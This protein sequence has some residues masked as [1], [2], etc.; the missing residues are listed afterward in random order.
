MWRYHKQGSRGKMKSIPHGRF[1]KGHAFD[2][3]ASCPFRIPLQNSRKCIQQLFRS[4]DSTPK[5]SFQ[6]CQAVAPPVPVWV[7]LGGYSGLLRQ[8]HTTTVTLGQM[9]LW[10]IVCLVLR[11]LFVSVWPCSELATCSGC[12]SPSPQGNRERLQYSG[13][14]ECRLKQWQL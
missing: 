1:E 7:H 13:N 3:D 10:M 9:R 5:R 8:R 4:E 2:Q 14:H 6:L 12:K 11:W